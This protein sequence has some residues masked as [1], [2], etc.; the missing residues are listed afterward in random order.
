MAA[1]CCENPARAF[2]L[3]PR[4]GALRVGSDADLALV[5][6]D[7]RRAVDAATQHGWS[8][9]SAYE[10][11][12]LVGWP[13]LTMLRGRVI[14]RDGVPIGPPTGRYLARQPSG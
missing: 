10:G 13:T 12:E 9:F 6:L 11:L 8:D 7:L 5:D 2:D 14:M 3:Y 4:K 1:V